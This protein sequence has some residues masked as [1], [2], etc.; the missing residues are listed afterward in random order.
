MWN[1][2][3]IQCLRGSSSVIY[4]ACQYKIYL[5]MTRR[6]LPYNLF[7]YPS[8][9]MMLRGKLFPPWDGM[10]FPPCHGNGNW[11][12]S[13]ISYISKIDHLCRKLSQSSIKRKK[14]SNWYETVQH[15]LACVDDNISDPFNCCKQD[16]SDERMK[17]N[18]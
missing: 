17:Y 10:N 15:I 6:A 3:G 14:L 18:G 9:T 4:E 13:S 1:I 5:W 11:P 2:S 8:V 16:P 12:I 7:L